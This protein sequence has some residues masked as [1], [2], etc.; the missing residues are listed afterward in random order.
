[1][2]LKKYNFFYKLFFITCFFTTTF[3]TQNAWGQNHY[4]LITSTSD[5]ATGEKYIISSAQSG[6]SAIILGYQATN[7]RPE[8]TATGGSPFTITSSVLTLTP[9][10]AK[11]NT[12]NPYEIT[13]EA[14]SDGSHYYLKDP[15]ST[16]PYLVPATGN[17]SN[18]YLKGKTTAGGSDWTI[19]FSSNAAVITNTGHPNTN[20]SRNI[21][22][23]NSS[24]KLFSCYSGGQNAVYLFRKAYKITY[25][26]NGS[27]GGSVPTDDSYYFSTETVTAKGNTDSLVKTGYS[28]SGWNTKA[29]GT[30]TDYAAGSGTFTTSQDTILYA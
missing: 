3:F 25:N 6:S 10:I 29:D 20:G 5:L 23:Y 2:R 19:T 11:T 13:I 16:D 17:N 22:R 4:K 18:N 12:D 9:A 27:T 21:I 28:F 26:A 1:M 8:A 14:G 15:L 24:A 7:N 30:G